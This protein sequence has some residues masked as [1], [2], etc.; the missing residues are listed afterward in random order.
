MANGII[1]PSGIPGMLPQA[2]PAGVAP[3]GVAYPPTI[4]A[5]EAA[6]PPAFAKGGVPRASNAFKPKK[7]PKVTKGALLSS[8]PGR[9]DQH[10]SYVPAGSYVIPADIVSGRGEGNTLAG[11][12]ALSKLFKLGPYGAELPKLR[13]AGGQVQE[14]E[15]VRVDLAGG[16]IVV[17]PESLQ[18]VVDPDLKKA[19]AIMDSWVLRERKMLQRT[20]SKLPGPAKGDE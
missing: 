11:V 7:L 18:A 19:H 1:P 9:T 14:P 16:E 12:E 20:L 5:A 6:Y 8:V 15:P 10:A 4:S 17:P 13:A 2:A 3:G